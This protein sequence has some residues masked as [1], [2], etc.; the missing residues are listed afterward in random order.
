MCKK[1]DRK[2]A[3]AKKMAGKKDKKVSVNSKDW[4]K[5][6]REKKRGDIDRYPVND[7]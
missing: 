3:I 2:E 5:E 6:H 4:V 7:D 1:C